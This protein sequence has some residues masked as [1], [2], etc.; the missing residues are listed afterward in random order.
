[1]SDAQQNRLNLHVIDDFEQNKAAVLMH[2]TFHIGS[3]VSNPRGEAFPAQTS[4][5]D[6]C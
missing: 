2:E 4:G 5:G 6:S 1:V 3:T